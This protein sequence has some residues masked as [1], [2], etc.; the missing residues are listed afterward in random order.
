[1]SSQSKKQELKSRWNE[2]ASKF[3]KLA[4]KSEHGEDSDVIPE[5]DHFNFVSE[6]IHLCSNE[7][8]EL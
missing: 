5:P 4:K 2:R 7:L 3:E 8:D 6:A 1:M